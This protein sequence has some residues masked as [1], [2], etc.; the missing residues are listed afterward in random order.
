MNVVPSF[1]MISFICSFSMSCFR[2]AFALAAAEAMTFAIRG[3][4]FFGVNLSISRAS[5]TPLRLTNPATKFAFFGDILMCFAVA[6][7]LVCFTWR[8]CLR[9]L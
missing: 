3:A 7:I 8:A 4:A 2:F 1:M 6:C 9:V 5:V